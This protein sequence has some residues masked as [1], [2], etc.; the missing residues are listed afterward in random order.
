MATSPKAPTTINPVAELF[1]LL[2]PSEA[3]AAF[4]AAHHAPAPSVEEVE[5]PAALGRTLARDVTSPIDLPA[6]PRS[7]VDGYAVRAADT[8]GSSDA[9]PA[10]LELAGES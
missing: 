1:H 7:T 9:Q 8:F 5:L 4:R 6:F 10:Y 3:Y 2:P